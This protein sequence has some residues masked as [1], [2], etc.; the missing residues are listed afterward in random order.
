[1]NYHTG[2]GLRGLRRKSNIL[3]VLTLKAKSALV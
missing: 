2:P 3:V 1:V